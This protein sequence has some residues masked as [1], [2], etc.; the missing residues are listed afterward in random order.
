MN[1]FFTGMMVGALKDDGTI[2]C[3]ASEDILKLLRIVLQYPARDVIWP[4][5]FAGVESGVFSSHC[6][7]TRSESGHWEGVGF[8]G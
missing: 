4:C 2:V 6:S 3:S 5:C 1:D 8:C 7:Q